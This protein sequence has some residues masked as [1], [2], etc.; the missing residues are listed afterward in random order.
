[1]RI[2]V[3]CGSRPGN[4]P[5]YL[6]AARELGEALAQAGCGIVY[7][8]A[9]VGLMGA[10]ADGALSAGGDVYGVI[11][12]ALVD[13]ELEHPRLT[14][15]QRVETMH[16]RKAA[17]ADAADGF[18]ALPGGIGTFEE[19]FEVWTWRYIGYHA[20]PCVLLDVDGYYA[21]LGAFLDHV[22]AEGFLT[23]ETLATLTIASSIPAALSAL[24]VPPR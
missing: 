8:G 4:R 6:A 20:K 5:S 17:M 14:R 24:G 13:R 21:K 23:P 19:I 2:A 15:L 22:V 12:Q 10:V 16:E 3:F 18:I 7:G 9:H 11:P 1:M